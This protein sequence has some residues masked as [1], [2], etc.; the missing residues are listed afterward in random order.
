MAETHGA[1]SNSKRNLLII[2]GGM[3]G[4]FFLWLAFRDISLVD[5]EDGVRKMK[6]WYL[7]PCLLLAI[8]CQFVQGN[9]IWGNPKPILFIKCQISLGFT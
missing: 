7:L 6:V 1:N 3:L 8:S 2:I 9:K 5:L 4:L